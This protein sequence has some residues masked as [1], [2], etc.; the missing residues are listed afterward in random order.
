[1]EYVRTKLG[2]EELVL[3]D[4][5]E[6]DVE[7]FV[8][9]WHDSPAQHLDFLGVD[10]EKLGVPD[11]TRERFRGSIRRDGDSDQERVVFV[12]TVAGRPVAYT[13]L[14]FVSADE[15]YVHGH[16][17]DP[18]MRGRG[19]GS[20]L[21]PRIVELAFRDFPIER[22]M[23]HTRPANSRVNHLLRSRLGVDQEVRDVRDPDGL[24]LPGEFCVAEID[25]ASVEQ[26]ACA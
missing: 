18:V 26:L 17:V 3:R 7:T 25:R 24:P 6:G 8:A 20:L 9:Y 2:E 1:M 11:D 13:N 10:R 23:L 22:L 21:A 12:V 15:N 5:E 4:L 14:H 16:V 19:I